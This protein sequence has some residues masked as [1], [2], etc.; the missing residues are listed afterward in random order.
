[1]SLIKN[2][3]IGKLAYCPFGKVPLVEEEIKDWATELYRKGLLP[4][5]IEMSEIVQKTHEGYSAIVKS[6]NGYK[7]MEGD[8]IVT[9]IVVNYA[10]RGTDQAWKYG[11][12][13]PIDII[14]YQGIIKVPYEAVQYKRRLR[15]LFPAL[16]VTKMGGRSILTW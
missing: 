7:Y 4:S 9:R 5:N 12:S 13:I 15:R 16:H 6:F 3:G 2:L 1:M 14:P 10:T 11:S 8:S